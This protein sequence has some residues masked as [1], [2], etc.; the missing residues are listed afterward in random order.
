MTD[1]KRTDNLSDVS[2]YIDEYFDDSAIPSNCLFQV[3]FVIIPR[4]EEDSEGTKSTQSK[5][6][7]IIEDI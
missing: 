6:T 5:A 3:G 4:S 2:S 7:H 1:V